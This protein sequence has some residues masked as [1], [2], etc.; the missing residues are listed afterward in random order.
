MVLVLIFTILFLPA[1]SQSED[2]F[3]ILL[4]HFRILCCETRGTND[5]VDH[6]LS[7]RAF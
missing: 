5:V 4:V 1:A 7:C 3:G 6:F 2:D